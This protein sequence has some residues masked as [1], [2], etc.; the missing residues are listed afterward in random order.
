VKIFHFV[1]TPWSE[2]KWSREL[3]ENFLKNCHIFEEES[4]EITQIFEEFGF[5]A[6]FF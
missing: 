1:R 5:L 6:F 4:Y 3:F 2:A